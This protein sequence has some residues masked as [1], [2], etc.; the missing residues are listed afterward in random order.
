MTIRTIVSNL[1]EDTDPTR[2]KWLRFIMCTYLTE[3][4]AKESEK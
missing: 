2:N 4:I 1:V 3:N